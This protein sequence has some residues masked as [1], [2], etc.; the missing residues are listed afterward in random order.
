M[1]RDPQTGVILGAAVEVHRCLGS[2]FL[3]AVY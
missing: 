1:D 2:G 3:E